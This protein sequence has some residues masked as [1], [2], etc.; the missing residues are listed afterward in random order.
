MDKEGA[1]AA[2]DEIAMIKYFGAKVLYDV[3]DR[4]IQVHGSLGYLDGS[5]AGAHVPGGTGRSN[6]RRPGRSAPCHRRPA[7]R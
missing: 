6:L 3:I 7:R 1:S 4:A 2:R 5:S